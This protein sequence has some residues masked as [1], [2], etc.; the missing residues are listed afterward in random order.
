MVAGRSATTF[1]LTSTGHQPGP[2]MKPKSWLFVCKVDLHTVV[3]SARGLVAQLQVQAA[4]GNANCLFCHDVL[5]MS[6]ASHVHS[7]VESKLTTFRGQRQL[8]RI[9]SSSAAYS[10]VHVIAMRFVFGC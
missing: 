7:H 2:E 10:V 1:A 3:C 6:H 8:I 5:L 4:F 9:R